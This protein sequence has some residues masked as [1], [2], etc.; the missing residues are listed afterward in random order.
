MGREG[1]NL[2]GFNRVTEFCCGE[3]VGYSPRAG[4][5]W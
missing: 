4:Q 1:A 2:G 3:R 5:F